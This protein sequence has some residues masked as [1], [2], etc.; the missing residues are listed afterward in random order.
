MTPLPRYHA[1]ARTGK[2]SC[3]YARLHRIILHTIFDL[4]AQAASSA[5]DHESSGTAEA[6][7]S[8]TGSTPR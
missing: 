1:I 6:C 3:A 4:S 2:Q 8:A 5:P 7:H